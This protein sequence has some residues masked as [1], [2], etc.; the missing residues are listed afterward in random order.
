[1]LEFAIVMLIDR[2]NRKT[3]HDRP[4]FGK[5]Y[6]PKKRS[7]SFNKI[8]ADAYDTNSVNTLDTPLMTTDTKKPI[9]LTDKIDFASLF[10][11]LFFY[12]LFNCVYVAKFG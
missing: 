6:N 2:T 10:F 9:L 12:I 5:L 11:Y 7:V 8:S 4:N 3:N 1:M